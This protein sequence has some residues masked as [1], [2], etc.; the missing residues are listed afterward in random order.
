MAAMTDVPRGDGAVE[1]R[2]DDVDGIR[3][4]EFGADLSPFVI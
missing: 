3:P 2:T 4:Y 1:A